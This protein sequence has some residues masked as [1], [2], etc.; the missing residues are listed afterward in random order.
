MAIAAGPAA[1]SGYD[2]VIGPLSNE[3]AEL[4]IRLREI[5]PADD[6]AGRDR[7]SLRR[8]LFA[9]L[10]ANTSAQGRA[11]A[12]GWLRR[13]A[14]TVGVVGL[15]EPSAQS[16]M[17]AIADSG[18]DLVVE[19]TYDSV[20]SAVALADELIESEPDAVVI[21]G[22]EEDTAALIDA[23]VASGG[24]GS[25]RAVRN[26]R[27]HRR[28]AGRPGGGPELDHRHDRNVPRC[29]HRR[30]VRSRLNDAGA[31]DDPTYA[32]ETYDAVVSGSVGRSA[33]TIPMP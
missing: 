8:T 4:T 6:H 1:R 29:T 5:R 33:S 26:R 2:V 24:F 14:T 10:V 30:R 32:A 18:L 27:Q 22:F 15:A 11:I 20:D 21:A 23:I 7:R 31:I 17:Q 25:V 12:T 9:R 16:I 13:G 28:R 19:E 3:M